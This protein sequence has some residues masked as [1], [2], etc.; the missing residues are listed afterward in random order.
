MKGCKPSN[1]KFFWGVSDKNKWHMIRVY[2]CVISDFSFLTYGMLL[3]DYKKYYNFTNKIFIDIII[4]LC[5]R[6]WKIIQYRF[7]S[8]V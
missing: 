2:Q 4:E 7:N 1:T 6:I 8:Y 5:V 3:T